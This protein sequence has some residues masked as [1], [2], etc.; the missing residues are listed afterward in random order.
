MRLEPP[1]GQ[2]LLVIDATDTGELVGWAGIPHRLGSESRATTGEVHAGDFDNPDCTQAFTYPFALALHDDGGAS[3]ARLRQVEPEYSREEHRR[4]FDIAGIPLLT[5][6]SFFN[7][8]R[9]V[10]TTRNDPFTDTPVLGDITAVNWNPGN[11]WSWMNPPLILTD[12]QLEASG[13]RQNWMGGVSAI[14]LRHAEDHALLFAAWL[15]ENHASPDFPF[16][17]LS[18]ADSPMGT[19]SGLSLVPYIREGRRILAQPAYG[20]SDFLLLE[21]DIRK[22]LPGGRDFS[23]TKVTFTHYPVDFHGCLYRNGEPTGEASSAPTLE[24]NIRP[25][26]IP[27]ES[28][29]PQG[30]DNLLIG[31]KGF[32]V[33]HIVNAAT[34]IH[35]GEWNVGAAAGAIAAYLTQPETPDT[36]AD[37]VPNG[38]MADLQT[39]LVEQGLRL[40]W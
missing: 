38:F 6:R 2:R 21:P 31:G 13:Q 40:D 17:V 8:R 39:Y 20:Q 4:R 11:D 30:V 7:Y 14:A 9:I 10:S 15:L 27:L 33:S 34:R 37:L 36:P 23:P 16:A 1:P 24:A 35:Y 5:G 29:I 19:Q 25:I 12:E 3:L 22:D 26:D 32:A 18:G 28:L